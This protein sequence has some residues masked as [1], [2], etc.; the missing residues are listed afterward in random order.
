MLNSLTLLQKPVEYHAHQLQQRPQNSP[1]KRPPETA[2]TKKPQLSGLSVLAT[3]LMDR[4]L[5][6]VGVAGFEPTTT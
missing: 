2:I 4:D 5:H 1:S 3:A 6:L